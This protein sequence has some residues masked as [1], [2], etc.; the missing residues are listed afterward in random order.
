MYIRLKR[1]KNK[2]GKTYT[3]AYLVK[4]R[5]YKTRS[6]KQKVLDYLGRV[7]DQTTIN[8]PK[9]CQTMPNNAKHNT[10]Q[11]F[12]QCILTLLNSEYNRFLTKIGE[13]KYETTK[14]EKAI[15]DLK[16]LRVYTKNTNKPACILI[17]DGFICDLTLK[18]IIN[19]KPP[20]ALEKEIG[21]V[22][23]KNLIFAGINPKEE[24][25]LNLFKMISIGNKGVH[26]Q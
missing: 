3:Y 4:I 6:P 10:K 9:Q 13:S 12:K 24:E 20:E 18:N 8:S 17:N 1:R 26:Q 11:T 5:G 19:F 25:F 14:E 15:I 23:A 16:E 2:S 22:L 21:H 7:F